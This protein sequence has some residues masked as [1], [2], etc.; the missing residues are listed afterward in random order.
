MRLDSYVSPD[1]H[2]NFHQAVATVVFAAQNR[3]SLIVPTDLLA[4]LRLFL[5]IPRH[6]VPT[7][8]RSA[9]MPI[10]LTP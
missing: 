10:P 2:S 1:G 6:C 3:G 8:G 4:D 7:S 9:K 5:C